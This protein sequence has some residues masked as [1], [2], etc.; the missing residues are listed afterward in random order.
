MSS[1]KV[2]ETRQFP[3]LQVN[4]PQFL[5]QL[6]DSDRPRWLPDESVC[7]L[8]VRTQSTG[9]SPLRNHIEETNSAQV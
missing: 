3:E 7:S 2:V 5:G 4:P 1:E 6:P 8:G 9:L